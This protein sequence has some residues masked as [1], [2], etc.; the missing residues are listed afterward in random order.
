LGATLQGNE[1]K[2]TEKSAIKS[3]KRALI[4]DIEEVR[5]YYWTFR[6]LLTPSEVAVY[7]KA[8]EINYI[9]GTTNI[10]GNTIS[11][12]QAFDLLVARV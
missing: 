9:Q 1:K 4:K 3:L 8:F 5:Q 12:D 10:E 11:R 6:R 7:E 2:R